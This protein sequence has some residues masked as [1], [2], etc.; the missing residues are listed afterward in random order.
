MVGALNSP[1][2]CP[3]TVIHGVAKALGRLGDPPRSRREGQPCPVKPQRCA[4]R[5]PLLQGHQAAILALCACRAAGCVSCRSVGWG[6]HLQ[7]FATRVR[8]PDPPL[9]C[10]HDLQHAADASDGW[11]DNG[12]AGRRSG[13]HRA[14]QGQGIKRPRPPPAPTRP[15]SRRRIQRRRSNSR[16]ETCRNSRAQR[17]KR[18]N[19]VREVEPLPTGAASPGSGASILSAH[20]I[21]AVQVFS[22]KHRRPRPVAD[23]DPRRA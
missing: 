1:W 9:P 21:Q 3:E 10:W 17:D 6:G 22:P 8:Q 11:P 4:T 12:K 14:N 18:A 20:S 2:L 13:E 5:P 23:K 15:R 7:S 16:P 19:S